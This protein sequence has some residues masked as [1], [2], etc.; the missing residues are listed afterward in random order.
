M[1]CRSGKKFALCLVVCWLLLSR[2][3][4]A[5]VC[6]EDEKYN[7]LT[8]T[9]EALIQQSNSDWIAL[10]Q[11]RAALIQSEE[12]Q[13][14]IY[15]ELT[16]SWMEIE[17]FPDLLNERDRYWQTQM[18]EQKANAILAGLMAGLSGLVIGLIAGLL[19]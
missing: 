16:T 14:I 1:I 13:T 4:W 11:L 5:E 8:T 10:N 3:S 17:K 2:T 9:V 15:N 19:L 6:L 12:T 18:Q 7:E